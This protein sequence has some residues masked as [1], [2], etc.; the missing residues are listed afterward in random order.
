MAFDKDMTGSHTSEDHFAGLDPA[1]GAPLQSALAFNDSMMAANPKAFLAQLA[2]E[3]LNNSV[4]VQREDIHVKAGFNVRVRKPK[5]LRHIRR[6]ADSILANGFYAHK[7]LICY[8]VQEGK[9]NV[10]YVVDGHCRL[11]AVDI[12][13]AEG[14]PIT[15]IPVILLDKSVS[16]ED[17]T[18]AL[19]R[20]SDGMDMGPLE[21]AIACKRLLG[22]GSSPQVIAERVGITVEYVHQLLTLAGSPK[23]IRAMVEEGQISAAEAVNA[24]RDYGSDA[25]AVIG[26]ALE[27]A[28]KAGKS[29]V[30][31]K[32]LPAQI[33]KRAVVKAAPRMFVVINRVAQHKAYRTLPSD[34]KAMIDEIIAG[35]PVPEDGDEGVNE[36]QGVLSLET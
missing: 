3:R 30:T 20:G 17:L 36:N 31:A 5:L 12:A 14:A 10:L 11:E 19:V 24:I 2:A 34:L 25:P 28:H 26:E 13:I 1:V 22:F 6:T 9:K 7:P 8:P 23:A 29:K 35:V 16:Q 18:V 33:R 32:F 21:V 15:E 27:A 4:K